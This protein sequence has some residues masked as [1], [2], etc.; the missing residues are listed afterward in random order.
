MVLC[1]L[2]RRAHFLI[3]PELK[4]LMLSHLL[5]LRMFILESRSLSDAILIKP[6]LVF[7]PSSKVD[8]DEDQIELLESKYVLTLYFSMKFSTT[9]FA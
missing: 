5:S 7:E 6:T 2:R 9:F 4:H 8:E 1:E 3:S